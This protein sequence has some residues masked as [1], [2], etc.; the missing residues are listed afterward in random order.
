MFQNIQAS[1]LKY[2]NEKAIF[3]NATAGYSFQ[4][5]NFDAFANE[6]QF[7]EVNLIGLEGLSM[8]SGSDMQALETFNATITISTLNDPNNMMLSFVVDAIY[9][10]LKPEQE[11]AIYNATTGLRTHLAKMYGITQISAVVRGNT[12]RV[13]QG[14]TFN[15]AVV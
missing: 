1:L 5:D 3:L 7:P 8:Q 4:A 6:S 12:A 15:G 11:I 13:Y 2:C 14:I 10:E 9:K